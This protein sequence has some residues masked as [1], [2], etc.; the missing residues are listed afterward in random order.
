M[1]TPSGLK[2]SEL[3][4]G[5]SPASGTDLLVLV[6][7]GNTVQVPVSGVRRNTTADL[8]ES[9]NLYYT[10]ARARAAFAA[11]N[12]LLYSSTNGTYELDPVYINNL[13]NS[14]N[15]TI[16]GVNIINTSSDGRRKTIKLLQKDGGVLSAEWI[17]Q[18][19]DIFLSGNDGLSVTISN[20]I[21]SLR[22]SDKGSSQNIFKTI[23]VSGSQSLIAN[24]NTDYITLIPGSNIGLSSDSGNRTLTISATGTSNPVTGV[25]AGTGISVS[26]VSGEV[27]V[28]NSDRGSS[29]N[30]FKTVAVSGLTSI[31]ATGNSDTLTFVAGSNINFSTDPTTNKLTIN[32]VSGAGLV[33][34][35]TSV[36]GLSGTVVLTTDNISEG[37]SQYF[38]TARARSAFS[39]GSGISISNGVI[40]NTDR[41]STG[42]VFKTISVS[43]QNSINASGSNSVLTFVA[44]NGISLT[45]DS[46]NKS[47]TI[48][49]SGGAGS[50]AGP[51]GSVQFNRLGS[52][53][54]TSAFS[55]DY[56]S[57]VL[58]KLYGNVKIYNTAT[59]TGLRVIGSGSPPNKLQTWESINNKVF[60]HISNSGCFV[61][62]VTPTISSVFENLVLTDEHNGMILHGGRESSSSGL[63]FYVTSGITI[64]SW[65]VQITQMGS[66][67]NIVQSSGAI[68]VLF[69]DDKSPI[70]RKRYSVINLYKNNDGANFI[71]YG[72]LAATGA[73]PVEPIDDLPAPPSCVG[74]S[75][76][77]PTIQFLQGELGV[78]SSDIILTTTTTYPDNN[79]YPTPQYP[80]YEINLAWSPAILIGKNT[81]FYTVTL[82]K[83]PSCYDYYLWGYDSFSTGSSTP[84]QTF[85]VAINIPS[86]YNNSV[87]PDGWY[88]TEKTFWVTLKPVGSNSFTT[89]FTIPVAQYRT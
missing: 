37:N 11:G 45:T 53:S 72:D 66:S 59:A 38:T 85:T 76:A 3:P 43:G 14:D 54:G 40:T 25:V 86:S 71:L 21:W 52:S 7:N 1:P 87:N 57:D 15:N 5:V 55:Y 30:I 13:S 77:P 26:R 69:P 48:T 6:Q 9:G 68:T 2:I 70:T 16:T 79:I 82:P 63:Y 39:A 56:S 8:P 47:I 10:N 35:V 22:N 27:T 19:Q 36:N 23:A 61:G 33:G 34:N 46:G 58:T 50:V 28:N 75:S 44:G 65:N 18:G 42:N 67:K 80:A 62:A 4:S 31:A 78:I 83:D 64:P 24:S 84:T 17:D 74:S 49:S 41:F 88:Y 73:T 32:A 81:A 60:S 20:G 51:T 89:T 29:Q 12:G